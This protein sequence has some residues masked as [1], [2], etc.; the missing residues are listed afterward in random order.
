[1]GSQPGHNVYITANVDDVESSV[2]P[3]RDSGMEHGPKMPRKWN[4]A[5]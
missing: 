3:N 5:V 4:A 2:P 1:M